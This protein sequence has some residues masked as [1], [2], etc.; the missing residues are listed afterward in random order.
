MMQSVKGG[1]ADHGPG[2]LGLNCPRLR[3]V[4][5]QPE[6]RPA[7]MV[8]VPVRGTDSDFDRGELYAQLKA[9]T[10]VRD[11]TSGELRY[12]WT[13]TGTLD[14]Y[15]HAHVFDHLAGMVYLVPGVR[16]LC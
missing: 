12:R 4:L 2:G 9:P 7:P 16:V 11:M 3:S 15:R 5:V 10:H 1:R 6:M 8:V 14:H 13:E